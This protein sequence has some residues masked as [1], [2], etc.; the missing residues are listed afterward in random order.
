MKNKKKKKTGEGL[1][2]ICWL[3]AAVMLLSGASV[4][5]AVFESPEDTETYQ[6]V[7]FLTDESG[8]V[9]DTGMAAAEEESVLPEELEMLGD[10]DQETEEG[11][12]PESGGDSAS[13][14]DE[15]DEPETDGED[16]P[17]PEEVSKL[18]VNFYS[19][20]GAGS[21]LK[22]LQVNPGTVIKLPDV[23]NSKYVNFGWTDI[24]S[25]AAVKYEIGASYTVN[26]NTN[27]Y[28]V[29]YA[30]SRV[31]TVTFAG[32]TGSVSAQ[33]KALKTTVLSGSTIKLPAVPKVTGYS[34]LG[35]SLKKN[36]S[37]AAYAAGRTI[38]VTQNLTL[39]AVRK[40]LASYS[41]TFN[42]NSGTSK[43]KSYT[44][45][46]KRIYKGEY[47]TLPSLPKASGYVNLGWTTTKKGTKVTHKAGSKV[48]VTKNLKFYAVRKK[49]TYYT[50]AFYS[51][52][53]SA[54]ST[55]KALNKK[56]LSGTS[57]TLPA[58][59]AR[60]GY[61]NL[62]W[63]TK[64][65]AS[66]ATYKAG[67]KLKISKNTKLY[68]VQKKEAK[69]VLHQN[70]GATWKT[71]TIAEGSSLTLPGVQNKKNYTMMGWS[72]SSG[73]KVNPE[74]QVGATLKN[75]KGTLHLYAVVF[76][77]RTEPDYP[78]YDLPQADL[79][80]YKQVI[81]VGDSR[82]NRMA[83]TLEMLGDA[84]LTN[85]ISFIYKEGGGLSWLQSEGYKA[86]LNKVADGSNSI[87]ERKTAVIFNLG[88]N[89][90]SNIYSYIT[91]MRSIAPTLEKKGCRL[92]Y[93]SV[94]P[95][96]NEMIKKVG[97][98]APRKEADV[99][100]F[101]TAVKSN[102][103]TGSGKLYTYIDCYGYLMNSGYGTDRNRNGQ[104]EDEDDGL[105]Y[106]TKTY[107]RIY[108]FCMSEIIKK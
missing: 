61:V 101:N 107:K 84:S 59:P 2:A 92:F 11:D 55:Y 96:N 32:P 60:S 40:K 51:S 27:L 63:S 38:K 105:H 57:I 16:P 72:R 17:K 23:P 100:K 36:A 24:R 5:A 66:S 13:E 12:L 48:K 20:S 39:Y 77:R 47:I 18:T 14:P 43:S 93:M 95:I 1:R 79:R 21:P 31:K 22:T 50:A 98:N 6:D 46:N 52:T 65:N 28:I 64:K 33:Y 78:A 91:F 69:V 83:N 30:A 8:A 97:R 7:E 80:S 41:V 25:S 94:N 3:L 67:A 26:V 42:N 73:K 37:T 75:I 81:F 34:S 58:V 68:A 54:S 9:S 15:G 4:Q 99:L 89:D 85:G 29:R 108:K 62:G 56:V 10:A 102:L 86:L 104:D 19:N 82:T 90:L 74:F 44:A 88:V 76:D 87:L 106:T 45:L 70:N 49:A 35:W 53:G 103:C 71:Y